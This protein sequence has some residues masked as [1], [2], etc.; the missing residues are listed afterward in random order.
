MKGEVILERQ[1]KGLEVARPLPCQVDGE[2]R[3]LTLEV[4]QLEM[5]MGPSIPLAQERLCTVGI[6]GNGLHPFLKGRM[7][8]Q[9]TDCQSVLWSPPPVLAVGLRRVLE[10][11]NSSKMHKCLWAEPLGER[12]PLAGKRERRYEL[13]VS[14]SERVCS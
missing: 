7:W 6:R 3:K 1:E 12:W 14:L 9:G 4:W 5:K 11:V 13:P 2:P 10:A 8:E